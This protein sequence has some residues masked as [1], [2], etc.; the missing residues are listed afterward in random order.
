MLKGAHPLENGSKLYAMYI[1]IIY[2]YVVVTTVTYCI[3]CDIRRTISHFE[4]HSAVESSLYLLPARFFLIY[5][6]HPQFQLVKP[7][8][9]RC[10]SLYLH[11]L[12]LRISLV[13]TVEHPLFL[14]IIGIKNAFESLLLDGLKPPIHRL[15]NH[16][17]LMCEIA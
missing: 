16:H 6:L 7:S 1:Y 12:L 17:S 4:R 13:C 9:F 8:R 2:I 5:L 15:L 10:F 14:T 11:F 3:L